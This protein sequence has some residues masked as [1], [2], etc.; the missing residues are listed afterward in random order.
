M[1]IGEGEESTRE[2]YGAFELYRRPA[3]HEAGP[4]R[5]A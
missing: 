3:T 1:E 4:I 2:R 5:E